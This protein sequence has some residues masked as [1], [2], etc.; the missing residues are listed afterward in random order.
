MRM[1]QKRMNIFKQFLKSL[2]S[3]KDIAKFRFQ[4]IGKTILFVFLLT[5]LSILPTTFQF[6]SVI[7]NGLE[8]TKDALTEEVPSFIIENGQ[9]SVESKTPYNFEKSGVTFIIDGT[10][11]IEQ[12]ELKQTETTIAL[13]KHEFVFI[14]GGQAQSSPYSMFPDMKMTNQ[15]IVEFIQSTE[16]LKYIFLPIMVLIIFIFS[17]GVKFIEVSILALIGILFKNLLKRNIP[18]RQAWRIAAYSVTL[19]TVFFAIMSFLQ[20]QVPNGFIINWFVSI[21]VLT[22]AIKEIPIK[23]Q[24][25]E[26]S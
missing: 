9:L 14:A 15:D 7:N 4:G 19:P 8:L 3:P 13:L 22:L 17:S 12:T 10:G 1:C 21:M 6:T 11:T 23:K 20:T 16:G 2:Y 25:V 18:Y 26:A 5:L 24:K